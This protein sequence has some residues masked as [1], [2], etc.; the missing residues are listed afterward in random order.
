MKKL[1]FVLAWTRDMYIFVPYFFFP[2]FLVRYI[3]L[4]L[5]TVSIVPDWTVG[6]LWPAIGLV[7]LWKILL[8]LLQIKTTK[9]Q[10]GL[11]LGAGVEAAL[12]LPQRGDLRAVLIWSCDA[13][14]E[15]WC[16]DGL[17]ER[18]TSVVSPG[19]QGGS[20]G[21]VV[22]RCDF[23]TDITA[24]LGSWRAPPGWE[25]LAS[26]HAELPRSAT[27]K[28][29]LNGAEQSLVSLPVSAVSHSASVSPTP[30]LPL[31]L[32][33]SELELVPLFIPQWQTFH[34]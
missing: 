27:D 11:K 34:S 17:A 24:H 32:Y 16:F 29:T 13:V 2:S 18:Q 4:N 12:E 8:F 15:I 31:L 28:P 9:K 25:S 22:G 23:V 14:Q 20:A 26:T 33:Q 3:C 21:G 5:G 10:R 7:S 30:F 6:P 1:C 19:D